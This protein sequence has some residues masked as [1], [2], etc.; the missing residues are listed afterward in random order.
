MKETKQDV[1]DE[2]LADYARAEKDCSVSTR[3]TSE[4]IDEWL[5][6]Y[7]KRYAEAEDL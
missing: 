6:S 3:L 5:E 7:R 2:L 4:K 1:F